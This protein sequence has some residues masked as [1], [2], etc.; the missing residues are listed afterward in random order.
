V[1]LPIAVATVLVLI[2]SVGYG[3]ALLLGE[4]LLATV[5]GSLTGRALG[6]HS[7]RLLTM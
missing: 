6:L 7:C 1:G 3:S 2:A 5:P 4:D